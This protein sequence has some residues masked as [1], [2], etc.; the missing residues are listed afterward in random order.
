MQRGDDGE[1]NGD[2]D[3]V[4]AGGREPP[5][6]PRQKRFDQ[7]RERGLA[8]PAERERCDR[9]VQLSG[10][11]IGV[12]IVDGPLQGLRVAP[13]GGDELSHTAPANCD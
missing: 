7:M 5:R 1:S 9:D 8:D 3:R 2:S 6:Q 12:Q 10:S 11:E 4:R 13:L